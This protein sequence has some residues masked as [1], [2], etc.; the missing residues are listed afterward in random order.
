M[1]APTSVAAQTDAQR[2]TA[3]QARGLAG[4]RRRAVA[5]RWVLAVITIALAAMFGAIL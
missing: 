1:S 3:W 2:W 5:M 4:D